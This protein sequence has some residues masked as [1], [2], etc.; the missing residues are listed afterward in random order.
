MYGA[1]CLLPELC[2]EMQTDAGKTAMSSG[3]FLQLFCV[4]FLAATEGDC[5]LFTD[6]VV[7]G[8]SVWLSYIRVV[9]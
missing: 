2:L 7:V 5:K 6:R 8:I 9:A 3:R 4:S 1:G